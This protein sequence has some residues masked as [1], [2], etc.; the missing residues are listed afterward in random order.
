MGNGDDTSGV[1]AAR[2]MRDSAGP[3]VEIRGE[4]LTLD[5]VVAVARRGAPVRITDDPEVRA[6]SKPR[7]N[8]W[9]TPRKWPIASTG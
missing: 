8:T 4:G 6:G 5:G 1:P 7:F 2:S 9:S 3:P